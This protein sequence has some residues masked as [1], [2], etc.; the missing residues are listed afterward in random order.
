MAL[1]KNLCRHYRISHRESLSITEVAKMFQRKIKYL[2]IRPGERFSSALT[3]INIS[4]RVYKHFGKIKLKYYIK[5]FI[6]NN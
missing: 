6:K 3:N 1:K 5:D 4:N 2:P